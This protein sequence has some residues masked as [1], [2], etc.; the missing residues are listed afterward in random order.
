MP[1]TTSSQ[2]SMPW[3]PLRQESAVASATMSAQCGCSWHFRCMYAGRH[4]MGKEMVSALL[5]VAWKCIRSNNSGSRLYRPLLSCRK[6]WPSSLD[7]NAK[8]SPTIIKTLRAGSLG[9][10]PL[11]PESV[12]LLSFLRF[13]PLEPESFLLLSLFLSLSLFFPLSLSLPLFLSLSLSLP[14]S[15]SS[16][17]SHSLCL[18]FSLCLSLSLRE[19]PR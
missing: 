7:A 16:S 3:S 2:Y 19:S 11:E 4:S 14:L 10:E 8:L 18:S 17:R 9:F 15:L 13:Q 1:G 5:S 12:L 6:A